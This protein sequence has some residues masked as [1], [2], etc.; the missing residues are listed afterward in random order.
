[1]VERRHEH[2]D[3]VA[4]DDPDAVEQ[5]LLRQPLPARRALRRAAAQ[6]VDELVDAA[7]ADDTGSSTGE[8]LPPCQLH[9]TAGLIRTSAL[10]SCLR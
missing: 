3:A 2:L 4:L 7:R 6:L 8:H 10:S 1:M 5:V 9:Q